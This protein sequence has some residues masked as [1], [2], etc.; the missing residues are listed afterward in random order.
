[1]N[2]EDLATCPISSTNKRASR[3]NE[4]VNVAS[5]TTNTSSS[6][7]MNQSRASAKYEKEFLSAGLWLTTVIFLAMTIAFATISGLLALFNVWWHPVNFLFSVF[8]LYIWNGI[9]IGFCSLTMIFWGSL[10]LIFITNNIGITDTLRT[11]AHYSSTDLANLGFSFWI[12]FVTIVCHAIN[13]GLIYYRNYLLQREP[14][15]PAITVNKNDSTLL[16]Y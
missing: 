4:Q 15:P 8:V 3:I 14:K 7:N 6:M 5:S 12:L 13:I 16:V 10:Y 11:S 1:M 2:D 9:A